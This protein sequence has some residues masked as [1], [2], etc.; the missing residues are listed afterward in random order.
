MAHKFAE[1]AFTEAVREVQ[2]QLGSRDSYA[3]MDNGEDYNHRLGDHEA[4]FLRARDSFYM[5][6]VSENGWPYLQ[7]RG[8]P[9]GFLQV[10]DEQ[11]LGFADF[12]GNRQ[13]VSVGNLRGNDRVALFL[14]DYASRTRLKLLG[15]VRLIG[16]E[17]PEL[18]ARLEMDNYRARVERGFVISIE[19]FDWNCPQ[20]ITPRYSEEQ[21][22]EL[23]APLKEENRQLRARMD[24]PAA[25]QL[26]E[27]PLALE[28]SAI[29][30][31][32][33]RIRSY[34]L[35]APDGS[36][37]PAVKAGAHLQLPVQ[38]PD[39]EMVSRHYSISSDPEHRHYY[40]IAVL[41]EDSGSGGSRALHRQYG[42]G[43]RLHCPP[44]GNYFPLHSDATPAVLIAGGIGITPIRA[45]ACSLR[46]RGVPFHIHYAGR[47]RPEMAFLEQLEREF[48]DRLTSYSSTDQQRL[49]I[50]RILSTAPAQT[51]FYSCGPGRLI[52]AVN[53]TA[54]R[55]GIA[56]GRLHSE[57][58]DP[59]VPEHGRPI[60]LDLRRSGR[61]LL[62]SAQNSILETL[63]EAGIDAPFGCR[64]GN[65][66]S[67]AVRVLEGKPDHRDNVLSERERNQQGLITPCVS[68][69]RSDH[70][71]LDL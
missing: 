55:L 8:G 28:I 40:E 71:V 27:G 39:G 23:L 14:M 45:M 67:C 70:L 2:R 7:H 65:C 53:D 6:T 17:E 51:H 35:R 16:A 25:E 69:A 5:A 34:E 66:R 13:Y 32:T 36:R 68:R 29:R 3:G 37:L 30:Q 57:R 58:F 64:T 4:S 49:D 26:G 43:T 44:P 22:N 24:S 62:V 1:I 47:E 15:R 19:A 56:S 21:L 18:L 38:L 42:I 11:T 50:N 60:R 12:S 46:A 63:E 52:D 9:A 20:H 33:P 31:L 10:L 41:A 59:G 61:Q 48:G 54:S